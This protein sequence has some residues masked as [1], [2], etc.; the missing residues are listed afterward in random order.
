MALAAA[1]LASEAEPSGLSSTAA[2][3]ERASC[4][5][6]SRKRVEWSSYVYIQYLYTWCSLYRMDPP[7]LSSTAAPLER[8]SYAAE[9]EGGP[10]MYRE[11]VSI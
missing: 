10:V 11:T 8:A 4:A 1:T 3:L 6:S 7:G 5:K 2:P 9:V